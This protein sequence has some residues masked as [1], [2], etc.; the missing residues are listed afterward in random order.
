MTMNLFGPLTLMLIVGVVMA[1]IA[2]KKNRNPFIWFFLAFVPALNM[3]FLITII[4]LPSIESSEY[5]A[6]DNS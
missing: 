3:I 1:L 6:D 5:E 2:K 4:F